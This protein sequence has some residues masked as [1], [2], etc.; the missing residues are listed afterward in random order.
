MVLLL[1][2]WTHD[3][4]HV[5]II[6]QQKDACHEQALGSSC[7][8]FAIGFVLGLLGRN[9]GQ[10]FNSPDP[11]P[12]P[13]SFRSKV[14][15]PTAAHSDLTFQTLNNW[16]GCMSNFSSIVRIL[17]WKTICIVLALTFSQSQA[18][19]ARVVSVYGG[20]RTCMVLMSDA[21]VWQWGYN[22]WGELGDATTTERHTPVQ[23]H[24]P[25]DIG[26]LNSIK[27]IMG[28]EPYNFA[29]KSDGTVWSWGWNYFVSLGDGTNTDS[30][31]RCRCMGQITSIS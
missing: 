22:P 16:L 10:A 13:L 17:D 19:A 26:F 4:V 25:N 7:R 20:A 9:L 27:A 21:T 29:S 5:L 6:N 14:E 31:A 28:G 1:C 12:L 8:P 18:L 24:G 11:L 15:F 30:H 2:S 3:R 23:V